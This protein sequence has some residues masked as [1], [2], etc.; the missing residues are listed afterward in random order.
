M[1]EDIDERRTLIAGHVAFAEIGDEVI[2]S[3][4]RMVPGNPQMHVV[5]AS[6]YLSQLF[7]IRD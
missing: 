1:Q 7:V 4:L 6:L 3:G 2:P 5:N